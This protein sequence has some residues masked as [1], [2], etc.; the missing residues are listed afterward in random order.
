MFSWKGVHAWS[1]LK[2]CFERKVCF[3]SMLWEYAASFFTSCVLSSP[4]IDILI[5]IARFLMYFIWYALQFLMQMYSISVQM[6]WGMKCTICNFVNIAWSICHASCHEMLH[7]HHLSSIICP[8]C[9]SISASASVH[10][11]HPQLSAS[12]FNAATELTAISTVLYM[13]M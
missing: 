7:Q 12:A 3:E 8:W 1:V 10:Q 9:S 4:Y 6:Y 2:V 5:C 11:Q 13:Y